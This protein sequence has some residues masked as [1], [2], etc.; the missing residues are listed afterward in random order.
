MSLLV[1]LALKMIPTFNC[2]PEKGN[3][4]GDF[5]HPESKILDIKRRKSSVIRDLSHHH[6]E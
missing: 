2:F 5:A 6:L 3:K 1:N 4:E